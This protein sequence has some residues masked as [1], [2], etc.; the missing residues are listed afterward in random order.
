MSVVSIVA[1][2]LILGGVA[3]SA[4]AGIGLLRFPNVFAR[5]HAATKPAVLGLMVVAA[6]SAL[7]VGG[8]GNVTRL[9]LVI[10]L[11]LVT[12][13]IAAHMIGRAAHERGADVGGPIDDLAA[14]RDGSED[15]STTGE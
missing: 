12:A 7:E 15:A 2:A 10:A 9:V 3:L 1:S 4:V 6:G 5:M 11:Q 8:T 14:E 13:P